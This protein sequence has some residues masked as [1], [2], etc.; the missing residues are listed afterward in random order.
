MTKHNGPGDGSLRLRKD[1]RWEYRVV[2]G[3]DKD[4]KPIRKS[5]FSRDKTGIGAKKK[6][7]EFL[8]TQEVPLEKIQTVEHWA[9][10][11]LETYKRTKVASKSYHNYELYVNKHIIPELG[12]MKLDQVRAAHIEKLFTSKANL[13][14]SARKHIDIA[15][16]AIFVTAI[17][18]RLCHENPTEEFKLEKKV[19]KSPV[20]YSGAEVNAILEFVKTHKWGH[21]VELLL[22]TGVRE[23][24]LC[25]LRWCDVHTDEFY[26]AIT[27]TVAEREPEGD[28]ALEYIKGKKKL[29][30]RYYEI[31]ETPKGNRDRN[32]TLTAK[33]AA[34]FDRVPKSGIFVLPG[35]GG[36]FLTPNQFIYRYETVF[37]AL[38]ADRA[39]R[40]IK[41]L[42]EI[43]NP[44]QEQIKAINESY[45]PVE[46]LSPHKCRHTYATHML[47]SGADI[48]TVQEQLGHADIT[49][50]ELYTKVD[51]ESRKNNVAKLSY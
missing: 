51:L 11:W 13:S 8:S 22:Y 41:A 19:K 15:L 26:I 32:V 9:K 28:E 42:S 23:G 45:A 31:K 10:Q 38:N 49:T 24:E 30:K 36:A 27:Q 6:Y 2:V 16:N 35:D 39:A 14:Y 7:K 48:R 43:E 44:T 1:G 18:N 37:K 25:G 40:R 4:D 3:R 34:C 5:F 33:G 47:R 46:L 12:K 29:R 20:A 17:K 50:T 21:F